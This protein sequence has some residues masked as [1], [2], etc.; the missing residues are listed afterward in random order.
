MDVRFG[1]GDGC[2][3]ERAGMLVIGTIPTLVAGWTR[4]ASMCRGQDRQEEEVE[5]EK[6]ERARRA[7][8]QCWFD[9]VDGALLVAT[10]MV[11][12]RWC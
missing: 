1:K 6:V 8:E 9:G 3:E 4:E 12:W 11:R 5:E 2:A 10:A 7:E